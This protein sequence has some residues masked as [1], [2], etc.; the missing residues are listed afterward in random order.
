VVC[1][2]K[3]QEGL[4]LIDIDLMNTS[5]LAKWLVRLN[6]ASVEGKWKLIIQA[7]YRNYVISSKTSLLESYC[8]R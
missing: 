5:L 3:K 1:K 8:K 7:K 4:G 2:N 6:D